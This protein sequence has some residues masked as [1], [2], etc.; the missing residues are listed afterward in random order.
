[1]YGNLASNGAVFNSN[2]LSSSAMITLQTDISK[3]SMSEF[4]LE[5]FSI[6]RTSITWSKSIINHYASNVVTVIH[7]PMLQVKFDFRLK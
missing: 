3:R 5:T 6:D 7:M 1:M 4:K 2:F